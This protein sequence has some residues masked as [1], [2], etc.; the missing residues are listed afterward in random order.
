MTKFSINT[1]LIKTI[2]AAA[3]GVAAVSP[4][5]ADEADI[6]V[7]STAAMEEWS[8]DTARSLDRRLVN[9]E[10]LSRVS[11]VS[12]IVQVRFELD[13]DG[14]PENLDVISSSGHRSTDGLAKRAVKGLRDLGGVPVANAGDQTF[15]AN[16]IFASNEGEYAKLAYKLEKLETAR[17]ARNDAEGGVISFGL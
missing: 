4:A 16:I 6:V 10:R 5:M 11:P 15:Q 8:A 3:L 7:Q 17:L 2:T 13:D 12:G 14:N 9:A 1:P